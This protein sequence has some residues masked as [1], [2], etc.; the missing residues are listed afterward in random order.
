[1]NE[2]IRIGMSTV[3]VFILLIS[4]TMCAFGDSNDA[5][6]NK[7]INDNLNRPNIVTI[8]NQGATINHTNTEWRLQNNLENIENDDIVVIESNWFDLNESEI[9]SSKIKALIENGNPVILKGKTYDAISSERTGYSTAF[10]EDGDLYGVMK[11]QN[12]WETYCLNVKGCSNYDVS[13]LAYEWIDHVQKQTI[14]NSDPVD[15]DPVL[16]AYTR[17]QDGFGEMTIETKY[18]SYNIGN[19]NYQILTEY[20]F[21]GDP[22]EEDSIWDN[23][24]S[25]ADLSI[26][27]DHQNSTLVS[28]GPLTTSNSTSTYSVNLNIQTNSG[29]LNKN[30]D[31]NVPESS[32]TID[33]SNNSFHISHDVDEKGSDKLSAKTMKPGTVSQT[34]IDGKV[35]YK[36]VE[37]YSVNYYKDRVLLSD[38]YSSDVCKMVVV[39]QDVNA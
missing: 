23:W 3:L 21:T 10:I 34:S 5:I 18:T 12:S 11:G 1:M 7:S 15:P 30:W 28:Y 33:C 9:T 32:L 2:K 39:L 38:E 24:I 17:V 8:S 29:I 35:I 36:E 14:M 26:T 31:Y 27:C 4:V 25:I 20:S 16:Y 37:I 13:E 19:G 22:F 6:Q